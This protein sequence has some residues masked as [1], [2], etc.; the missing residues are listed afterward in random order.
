MEYHSAIKRNE[1]MP[2]A[3]TWM[4]LEITI[5]IN[6]KE[7]D[8]YHITYMWNLK[9]DRNAPIQEA[10]TDSQTENRLVIIKGRVR[11]GYTGSLGLVDA[12]YYL[13]KGWTTRFLLYTGKIYSGKYIQCPGIAIM[14]KYEKYMYLYMCNLVTLLCSR[15]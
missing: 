2:F 7:K 6:Q 1:I 3:A 8:K 4:Q 14:E 5:L 9:Y 15:N 10:E 13:L 12:N 11:E